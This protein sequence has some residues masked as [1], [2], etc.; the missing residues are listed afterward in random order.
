MNINLDDVR[1]TMFE[2]KGLRYA[3][4]WDINIIKSGLSYKA[5]DDDIF[6]SSYP[7]SG[8]NWL[9]FMVYLILHDGVPPDDYYTIWKLCPCLE[10]N[11]SDFVENRISTSFILITEISCLTQ[12]GC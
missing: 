9:A 12:I 6:I 4:N 7:K 11:G 3:S 2:I 8:T 1:P 10:L 5:K